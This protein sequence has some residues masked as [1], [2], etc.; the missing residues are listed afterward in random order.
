MMSNA[1][2]ISMLAT[3]GGVFLPS[4]ALTSRTKAPSLWTAAFARPIST[5]RR[6]DSSFATRLRLTP[7]CRS[8][9]PRSSSSLCMSALMSQEQ[10][11]RPFPRPCL[12]ETPTLP[13]VRVFY[14]LGGR[15]SSATSTVVAPATD[16]QREAQIEARNWESSLNRRLAQISADRRG[17]AAALV[18]RPPLR[19]LRAPR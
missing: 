5:D 10:P 19:T 13:T 14:H 16:S 11:S 8:M 15:V 18:G 12:R 2:R 9:G 7:L 6:A 17:H 1:S 3:S 4:S